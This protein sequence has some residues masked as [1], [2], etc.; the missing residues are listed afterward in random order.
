MATS[1]FS[2]GEKANFRISLRAH[3]GE[4]LEGW[5]V[6]IFAAPDPARGS[7][8][9]GISWQ[10]LFP[11][12]EIQTDSAGLATAGNFPHGHYFVVTSRSGALI[13]ASDR[14]EIRGERETDPFEVAVP[15]HNIVTA[16]ARDAVSDAEI[17]DAEVL[18]K[19]ES[20][21]PGGEGVVLRAPTAP[22]GTFLISASAGAFDRL[23]CRARVSRS[24]YA[25][26]VI[27][28]LRDLATDAAGRKIIALRQGKA[29]R[30]ELVPPSFGLIDRPVQVLLQFP[31]SAV[32]LRVASEAGGRFELADVPDEGEVAVQLLDEKWYVDGTQAQGDRGH[33]GL[34]SVISG[35][36]NTL[37]IPVAHGAKIVGRL[38]DSRTGNGVPSVTVRAQSLALAREEFRRSE[39]ISNQEGA[40]ELGDLAPG[41]HRLEA[42][43]TL[44]TLDSHEVQTRWPPRSALSGLVLSGSE[45][46]RRAYSVEIGSALEILV[47]PTDTAAV[48]LPM[49]RLG[50]VTGRVLESQGEVISGAK[51]QVVLDD[52]PR[53]FSGERALALREGRLST[54]SKSDGTYTLDQIEPGDWNL[55]AVTSRGLQSEITRITLPQGAD[56][57]RVD[58]TVRRGN[59]MSLRAT[60][61]RGVPVAGLEAAVTSGGQ[62]TTGETSLLALLITAQDGLATADVGHSRSVVLRYRNLKEL[63]LVLEGGRGE[64]IVHRIE[65]LEG[66]ETPVEVKLFRRHQISVR[67]LS[68]EGAAIVGA[69]VQFDRLEADG[70]VVPLA[71]D[72]TRTDGSGRARRFVDREG[73]YRVR[74]VSPLGS[75]VGAGLSSSGFELLD[76]APLFTSETESVVLV[77]PK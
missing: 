26:A 67:I 36:V 64:E 4:A 21:Q 27:K 8:S 1:L 69:L 57:A 32:S 23:H 12:S 61:D 47:R 9:S 46:A 30:G 15:P 31:T 73:A 75:P 13:H 74:S 2:Q 53:R 34:F 43:G 10:P 6:L 45:D 17:R 28:E 41:W 70:S 49:V 59:R 24:G 7:E 29:L 55:R 72:W 14:F 65:L 40:F 52:D 3:T 5:G 38:I 16:I 44:F 68:A 48:D 54:V 19:L 63:G 11:L 56:E 71:F 58:L 37:R 35:A 22:D 62:M 33:L 20:R 18:I 39:T 60:T 50:R 42:K 76:A 25:P 77:R 66:Q 51:V